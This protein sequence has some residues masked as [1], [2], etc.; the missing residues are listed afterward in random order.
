MKSESSQSDATNT[1]MV[2]IIFLQITNLLEFFLTNI[3]KRRSMDFVVRLMT[4]DKRKIVFI[5][6]HL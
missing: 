4:H 2:Q 3:T 1:P 5:H 6:S